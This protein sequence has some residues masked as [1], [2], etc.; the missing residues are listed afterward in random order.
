MK[1]SRA[2]ITRKAHRAFGNEVS[3]AETV[4]ALHLD[5]QQ[6]ERAYRDIVAQRRTAKQLEQMALLVESPPNREPLA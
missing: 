4:A 2:D 3:P 1:H 5:E 6:V